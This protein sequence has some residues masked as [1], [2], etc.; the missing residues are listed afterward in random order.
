MYLNTPFEVDSN[1]IH[2]NQGIAIMHQYGSQFSIDAQNNWWGDPSGPYH[3]TLNPQGQGDTVGV[4]VLFDPWLTQPV[5][6]I[7]VLRSS[8]PLHFELLSPYPNPSNASTIIRYRVQS[9][10]NVSLKV[11]DLTGRMTGELFYGFQLP[12]TYSFTWDASQKASGVYVVRLQASG[13]GTTQTTMAKKA[14]IVK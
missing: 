13:S 2:G 11:Y 5:G 3:P 4:G 14:V 7:P 6:V 9:A 12:G 10:G 8:S 1:N